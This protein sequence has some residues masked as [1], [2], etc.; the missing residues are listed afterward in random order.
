MLLKKVETYNLDMKQQWK[1]ISLNIFNYPPR[2]L[3]KVAREQVVII[4]YKPIPSFLPNTV[5]LSSP[6]GPGQ[7][8]RA[9]AWQAGLR[10]LSGRKLNQENK[11]RFSVFSPIYCVAINVSPGTRKQPGTPSGNILAL[12]VGLVLCF[13]QG[14]WD[15]DLP[16][17]NSGNGV[18]CIVHDVT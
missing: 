18:F 3:F 1:K 12:C 13:S 2:I 11:K 9:V 14:L 4:L 6:F 17:G 7:S 15:S 8:S 16:W 5:F 10:N